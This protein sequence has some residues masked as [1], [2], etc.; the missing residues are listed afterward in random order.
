MI[1]YRVLVAVLLLPAMAAAR[2]SGRAAAGREVPAVV[3]RP[4]DDGRALVNP[5]MG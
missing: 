2:V 5:G 3:V 4:V 1:G